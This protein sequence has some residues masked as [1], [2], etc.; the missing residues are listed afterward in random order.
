MQFIFFKPALGGEVFFKEPFTGFFVYES[1]CLFG[2][3]LALNGCGS[4][5]EGNIYLSLKFF[6]LELYRGIVLGTAC[7]TLPD[8]KIAVLF[9]GTKRGIFDA[10][11]VLALGLPDPQSSTPARINLSQICTQAAG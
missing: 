10:D 1:L 4:L 8:G 11:S 9:Q 5:L 7:R 2:K 6:M 3:K